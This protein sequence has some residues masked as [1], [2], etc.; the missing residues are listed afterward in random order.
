MAEDA[1]PSID[2]LEAMGAVIGEISYDKKNVFDTTSAWRKQ[3]F[4]QACQ[5]VAY[6]HARFGHKATVA[7]QA[8]RQ[9]FE[10]ADRGVGKTASSRTIIFMTSKSSRPDMKMASL[11]FAFEHATYGR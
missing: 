3:V 8:G 9:V 4:V 10:S 6:H 11:I 2:E 1:L 7:F 5:P